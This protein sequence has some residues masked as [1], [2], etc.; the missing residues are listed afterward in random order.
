ILA[1]SAL[2]LAEDRAVLDILMARAKAGVRVRVLL[3]DPEGK[4]VAARGTD[5][6]IGAE[7]MAARVRNA[8]MLY[9]PLR[10]V[11]DVEIRL[12]RTVLYNSIYQADD[13]LL[14]NTHAYGTPAADAPV[15]HLTGSDDG[16]PA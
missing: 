12:H 14:V 16:G 15:M 3:G 13:E 9:R 11:Q 2:F 8:L 1:Y 6:G 7:V 4:E 5:E 10:G